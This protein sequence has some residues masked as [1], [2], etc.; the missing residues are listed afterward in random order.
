MGVV[1]D[2]DDDRRILDQQLPLSL[3]IMENQARKG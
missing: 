1:D 2:D 3:Y